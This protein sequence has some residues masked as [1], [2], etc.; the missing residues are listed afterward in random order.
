[1]AFTFYEFSVTQ[2]GKSIRDALEDYFGEYEEGENEDG[3]QSF[4][5][6]DE[7]DVVFR[8]KGVSDLVVNFAE[9]RSGDKLY[10]NLVV[11]EDY[12]EGLIN[13]EKIGEG[14]RFSTNSQ[15]FLGVGDNLLVYAQAEP[16]STNQTHIWMVGRV[17]GKNLAVS[18]C[19]HSGAE[20]VG[21]YYDENFNQTGC[22]LV[23]GAPKPPAITETGEVL[24]GN[25]YLSDKSGR[26]LSNGGGGL[27]VL[28]Y[29]KATSLFFGAAASFL[30]GEKWI[31]FGQGFAQNMADDDRLPGP[32]LVRET[33]E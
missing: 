32:I 6:D 30:W 24:K 9:W 25:V 28:P 26:L 3:Y 22:R 18:V 5:H 1:M 10:R 4:E 14:D 21:V 2:P 7:G 20:N 23:M 33:E 17:G 31:V 27:A 13:S 8:C 12:D 16:G 19:P 15:W 29:I 11:A